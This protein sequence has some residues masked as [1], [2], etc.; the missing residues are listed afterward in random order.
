MLHRDAARSPLRPSRRRRSSRTPQRGDRRRWPRLSRCGADVVVPHAPWRRCRRLVPSGTCHSCKARSGR[1]LNLV[2]PEQGRQVVAVIGAKQESENH[3][4]RQPCGAEQLV[5]GRKA[6]RC[7]AARRQDRAGDRPG[8]RTTLPRN[9]LPL[10]A[11]STAKDAGEP[12]ARV[13]PV[14]R[15]IAGNVIPFR[16]P[17]VMPARSRRPFGEPPRVRAGRSEFTDSRATACLQLRGR[18]L[19]EPVFAGH[20][21]GP[22]IIAGG[23]WG[24]RR[25]TNPGFFPH[26]WPVEPESQDR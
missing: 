21:S 10:R 14:A 6:F 25:P 9:M 15:L 23:C 3:A 24:P 1:R 11:L 12:V 16:W 8:R 2:K 22:M 19:P 20:D 13:E 5:R 4:E 26:I 7:Q 18:S 17:S